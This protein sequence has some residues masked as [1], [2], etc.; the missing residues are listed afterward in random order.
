MTNL[1]NAWTA[2]WENTRYST[3]FLPLSWRLDLY[4]SG[5]AKWRQGEIDTAVEI[6][7]RQMAGSIVSHERAAEQLWHTLKDIDQYA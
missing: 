4:Q 2:L 3:R 7:R 6:F 5:M 1:R